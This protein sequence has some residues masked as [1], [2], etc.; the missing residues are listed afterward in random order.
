MKLPLLF[1]IRTFVKNMI[2]IMVGFGVSV[3]SVLAYYVY[4]KRRRDWLE[5]RQMD[6]FI[7]SLIWDADDRRWVV[8]EKE[9]ITSIKTCP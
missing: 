4:K 9:E 5:Q 2:E 6:M 8:D 3:F 1:S 7:E